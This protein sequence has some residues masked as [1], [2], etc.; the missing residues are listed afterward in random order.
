M[1]DKLE[2]NFQG[3]AGYYELVK[4]NRNYRSL[5][6]GEIVSLFGDW[7]NLIAS[8][9]LISSLT[10]SGMAV[11]GLFVVR[12]LAPFLV[13]PIAGV[14]ADRFDQR[15]VLI[16]A[17]ISRAVIVLG[18]LLVR[19]AEQVWLLYVLTLLQLGIS[20][21][22]YPTRNSLL[23]EIVSRRELGSANALSAATWSVMLALG[24][25]VGG[26][27]A[28][29]WGIY[30]AFVIDSLTFLVSALFIYQIAYRHAPQENGKERSI[31]AISMDYIEGLR[32]SFSHHDILAISLQKGGWALFL[33]GAFQVVQVV[34]AEKIFVIG[35]GGSTSLGL[36]YAISG[37]GTGLG[38]IF[39]R[40]YSGDRD[41][42]LRK[43]ISV[44]YAIGIL[45]TVI[46]A[47][48]ATFPLVLLGSLL[49]SFGGG[50]NWVFSTQLLLQLTPNRVRGRVFS[51]EFAVFTLA[52]AMGAAL[53]GWALDNSELTI[54][55]M[56]WAMAA[57]TLIPIVSW[58]AWMKFGERQT[59][60][61]SQP[62]ESVA[63]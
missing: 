20:G 14:V 27:V 9:A 16:I 42:L 57:L 50:I 60:P 15:R 32:Y 61:G 62:D 52:N 33:G 25:A 31:R 23:P 54:S 45:G 37:I 30:P 39:A 2:T 59:P 55:G 36:I 40:Y 44:A 56:L 5:W 11:G 38:P 22:F 29:S 35:E 7:F 48:L 41:T 53:G 26:I 1:T 51:T 46:I 3:Q 13:S 18:F 28:G 8:A 21:F 6:F 47:P 4:G 43:F 49:R 63:P 34:I 12:M 19:S 17:D 10:G 24:A 58:M